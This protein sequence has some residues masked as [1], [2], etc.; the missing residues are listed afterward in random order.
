MYISCVWLDFYCM[1]V[2]DTPTSHLYI[3][4]FFV[5]QMLCNTHCTRP[6]KIKSKIKYIYIYYFN[7]KSDSMKWGFVN[8]TA[9]AK[10]KMGKSVK[11]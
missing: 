5:C 8:F 11:V 6:N 1:A 4:Y 2:N 10:S 3:W 7:I 9:A